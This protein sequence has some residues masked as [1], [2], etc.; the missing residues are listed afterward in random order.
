MDGPK[1]VIELQKAKTMEW[2][3]SVIQGHTEI[4]TTKIIPDNSKPDELD[5]ETRSIVE[6]MMVRQSIGFNLILKL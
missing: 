5:S 1:L 2:W 4:D 6:K 3:K